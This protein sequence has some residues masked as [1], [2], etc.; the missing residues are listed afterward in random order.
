[1]D[2]LPWAAVDCSGISSSAPEDV[3]AGVL[4]VTIEDTEVDF[5]ISKDVESLD[6]EVGGMSDV[7]TELDPMLPRLSPEPP[8]RDSSLIV[9]C[10]V[11]S[12]N[13]A[14]DVKSTRDSEWVL[15]VG[16][17]IDEDSEFPVDVAVVA[18]SDTPSLDAILPRVLLLICDIDPGRE[19]IVR[20]SV[21][22]AVVC[23]AS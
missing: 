17:L 12:G 2:R 15:D 13:G 14:P 4:E 8:L 1:M 22:D 23:E 5:E 20:I 9:V 19:E 3:V 10:N 6:R 16:S 21:S 18:T 7:D 11:V